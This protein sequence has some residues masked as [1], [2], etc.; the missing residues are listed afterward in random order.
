MKQNPKT[1]NLNNHLP[2][3]PIRKNLR[4]NLTPAEAKLW[5]YYKN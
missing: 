1:K 5:T 2:L 4:N 3:K